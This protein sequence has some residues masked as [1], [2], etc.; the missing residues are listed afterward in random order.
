VQPPRA[1]ISDKVAA[2]LLC[3]ADHT[4]CICRNKKFDVQIHHISGRMDSR[5][6]NLIVLCLNCHSDVERKGGL[7]R[8]YSPNELRRYKE[9]AI[10]EI[11]MRR[12]QAKA[13]DQSLVLFEVKR[14]T[15]KFQALDSK[16]ERRALEIMRQVL[17][18][19]RY[20]T[21]EVKE[22][23]VS[24]VYET[25]DWLRRGIRVSK[26]FVSH[27]TSIL[28]ECSPIITLVAP[29]RKPLSKQDLKL[30]KHIIDVSGEIAYGVC[31][32]TENEEAAQD[33]IF[34]LHDLL[35]FA[36]LNDLNEYEKEILREF[37]ECERISRGHFEAALT[38]LDLAKNQALAYAQ[39]DKKKRV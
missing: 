18:F 3:E 23:C 30:L 2:Q 35:R 16:D 37:A 22:D 1:P 17:L 26:E 10:R 21:Y 13:L 33:A 31:K 27:Q 4:C 7:G 14:L 24:F 32:Y 36:I 12:K 6:A 38:H 9:S 11:A 20:S 29:S 34:A 28:M 19:G 25:S 8:V 5:P 15:Y 39:K